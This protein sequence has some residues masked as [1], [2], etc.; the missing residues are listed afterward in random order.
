MGLH[1]NCLSYK[2]ISMTISIG[3]TINIGLSID[4]SI[5]TSKVVKVISVEGSVLEQRSKSGLSFPSLQ[6]PW[7]IVIM[8][9]CHH[10]TMSLCKHVIMSPCLYVN[11][12]SCHYVTIS[13]CVC[14]CTLG[15]F[16]YVAIHIHPY[17]WGCSW[18]CRRV[19]QCDCRWPCHRQRTWQALWHC[20]CIPVPV[21]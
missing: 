2:S 15:S 6:S 9:L 13:P 8:L 18:D 1:L 19:Y 16:F 5:Y 7:N 10:V 14:P 17:R 11:M 21:G 3:M 12:S 20:W 4:L